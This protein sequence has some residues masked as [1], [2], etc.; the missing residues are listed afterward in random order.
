MTTGAFQDATGSISY[1]PVE[2]SSESSQTA[3]YSVAVERTGDSTVRVTVGPT[4]TVEERLALGLSFGDEASIT[5]LGRDRSMTGSTT[6]SVE[7]D[8]SQP[9]GQQAYE[10]FLRT[11]ELPTQEGPGIPDTYQ[12]QTL[13]YE[14]GLDAGIS[15]GEALNLEH[16]F[17][18]ND[19]TYTRR[20]DDGVASVTANGH[21]STGNAF[22]NQLHA[23]P[24]WLPDAELSDD[25]DAGAGADN[26][27]KITLTGP[28]GVHSMQEVAFQRAQTA[29]FEVLRDDVPELKGASNGE[30]RIRSGP[31]WTRTPGSTSSARSRGTLGSR[32]RAGRTSTTR[33]IRPGPGLRC[34]TSPTAC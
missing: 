34:P 29:A 7:F 3:G 32:T 13:S 24:G 8:L 9:E 20:V 27:V 28:E 26:P 4:A 31:T 22:E 5:L 12:E 17:W 21:S 18:T 25:G 19:L 15:L 16:Q 1:G 11:G 6:A 14:G 23:E 30:V 2:L 33:P 10:N